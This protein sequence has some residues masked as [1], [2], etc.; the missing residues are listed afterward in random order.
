MFTQGFGEVLADIMTVSPI[1]SSIPTASSILDASNYTFNAI[2]YSKDAQGFK[3]HGHTVSSI[4]SSSTYNNGFLQ[5]VKY[6]RDSNS[7]SSYHSSATQYYLSA[8]YI[9]S[10]PCYPSIYDTRL[11]RA[12]TLTNIAGTSD[13]GHYLNAAIDPQ[14]SSLWNVIGG[15]PPSGNV[16]KYMMLSSTGTFMFSGNLSG[17]YNTFGIVDKLGFIN[18]VPLNATANST[19]PAFSGPFLNADISTFSSNPQLNILA[20]PQLGDYASLCAFGGVT[21]IGVWCLDL[22]EMLRQGLNPPYAWN[23]LN[24]NRRYKLVAKSTLWRDLTHHDDAINPLLQLILTIDG[25]SYSGFRTFMVDG[26]NEIGRLGPAW[27]ININ[28]A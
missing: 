24:N 13:V 8:S 21:H 4:Q 26:Y 7:V 14:F 17:V 23:H 9:S 1:L 6:N 19:T 28:F 20:G 18:M 16:G 27:V 3:F 22:K 25:K 10:L 12:S 5:F 15:Y 11:E 2:T